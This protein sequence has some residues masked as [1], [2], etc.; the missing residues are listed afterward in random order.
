MNDHLSRLYFRE[1]ILADL[2][3]HPSDVGDVTTVSRSGGKD[4]QLTAIAPC[5]HNWKRL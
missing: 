1:L 3:N 4:F 2:I 5:R